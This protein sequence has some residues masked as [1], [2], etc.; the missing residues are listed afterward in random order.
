M[1]TDLSNEDQPVAGVPANSPEAPEAI[2]EAGKAG[3]FDWRILLALSLTSL[4]LVSG[5]YYLDNYVGW[6]MFLAQPIESIGSFLEGAFAPLAFL[7]LVV[8]YFLQQQ[9][10]SRNTLAIERQHIE[11]QKAS[12]QAELQSQAFQDNALHTRQQTF[13]QLYTVVKESLGAVVGML[14][15]SSQAA[16]DIEQ[17]REENVVEL[18]EQMTHGDPELFARKFLQL[19][20]TG[21]Q[22]FNQLFYGTEIRTRHT[23]NFIFQFER[24]VGVARDCDPAGIIVDAVSSDALGRLY[25]LMVTQR[26]AGLAGGQ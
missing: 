17:P 5:V 26:D 8:G 22:D 10:L 14:Y 21:E 20:A 18:W 19:S 7:W 9:E 24:L 4:W 12:V 1:S 25:L 23:N 15:I 13:M 6:S 11:L 3:Y 2:L 16:P